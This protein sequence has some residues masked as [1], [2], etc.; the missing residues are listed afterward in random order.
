MTLDR[1]ERFKRLTFEDTSAGSAVSE[2]PACCMQGLRRLMTTLRFVKIGRTPVLDRT[3]GE[4][5]LRSAT[6]IISENGVYKVW[7]V[8]GLAWISVDGRPCRSYVVRHAPYL[9]RPKL[10]ARG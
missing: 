1:F 10:D 4:P 7:Y 3:P 6:A 2:C 5:F 9:R 8:S